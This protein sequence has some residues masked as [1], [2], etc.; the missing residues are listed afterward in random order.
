MKQIA[1]G[2]QATL[3]PLFSVSQILPRKSGLA[4]TL[5][6]RR[7][8]PAGAGFWPHLASHSSHPRSAKPALSLLTHLAPSL[9]QASTHPAS[10][11]L[12]AACVHR[13]PRPAKGAGFALAAG[14]NN[15]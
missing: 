7:A 9:P 6:S 10:G 11:S 2:L 4:G 1:A 5:S 3:H 8:E 14:E 13:S 12:P 15:G